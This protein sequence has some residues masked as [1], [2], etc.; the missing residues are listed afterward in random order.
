[1]LRELT[2]EVM[3]VLEPRQLGHR[4]EKQILQHSSRFFSPLRFPQNDSN[5]NT[6]SERSEDL[7]ARSE[8]TCFLRFAPRSWPL[9]LQRG[10]DTT[11]KPSDRLLSRCAST[12]LIGQPRILYSCLSTVGSLSIGHSVSWNEPPLFSVA[13]CGFTKGST[14]SFDYGNFCSD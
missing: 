6:S 9:V 5:F 14:F 4:N 11:G 12:P 2:P 8:G 3:R 10:G 13:S 7:A 1:M